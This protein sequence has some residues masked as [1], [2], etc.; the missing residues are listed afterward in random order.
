MNDIERK[1][2][3]IGVGDEAQNVVKYH[4]WFES[5]TLEWFESSGKLMWKKI[6]T[7][8]K[9]HFS[10]I[11]IKSNLWFDSTYVWFESWR[12]DDST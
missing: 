5:Q 1:K 8:R 6:Y 11:R 3:F 10:M 12:S 9:T 2:W 4:I 7:L